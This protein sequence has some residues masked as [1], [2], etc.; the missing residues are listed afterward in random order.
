MDL[1]GEIKNFA[2]AHTDITLQLETP[3]NFCIRHIHVEWGKSELANV[4]T[5]FGT[6][7]MY[8]IARKTNGWMHNYNGNVRFENGKFVHNLLF[9]GVL[10][11]AMT[12]SKEHKYVSNAAVPYIQGKI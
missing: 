4:R 2:H 9:F 7:T 11:C 5:P 12:Y 8:R 6:E 10:H 3:G 1:G